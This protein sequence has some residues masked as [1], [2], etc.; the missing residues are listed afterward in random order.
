MKKLFYWIYSYHYCK[1]ANELEEDE[2]G[3]GGGGDGVVV[4]VGEFVPYRASRLRICPYRHVSLVG[5]R[6]A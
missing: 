2:E 1:R 5:V 6:L 4:V 3:G